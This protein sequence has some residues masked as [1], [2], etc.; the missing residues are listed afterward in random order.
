MKNEIIDLNH[1]W[2]EKKAEEYFLKMCGPIDWLA[3]KIVDIKNKGKNEWNVKV[4]VSSYGP[5]VMNNH[6]M[7]IEGKSFHCNVLSQIDREHVILI[8]AYMLTVGERGLSCK[9]LLEQYYIDTWGTAY[10]DASREILKLM[11]IEKAK[12][13]FIQNH[14]HSNYQNSNRRDIEE[15]KLLISDS[16]GPGYYGMDISSVDNFFHILD[17]DK[18][19]IKQ[20]ESGFMVP[21][22]SNVGFF[23]VTDKKIEIPYRDCKTCLGTTSGCDYCNSLKRSMNNDGKVKDESMKVTFLPQQIQIKASKEE[24][25]LD[26]ARRAG[27]FI[28]GTC[29]HTG[30]C[31]KCKVKITIGKTSDLDED[32][33]NR[34]TEEEMKKGYRLACKVHP[35][36]DVRVFV[37]ESE[38]K[39]KRKSELIYMPED[40]TIDEYKDQNGIAFDIGTTSVVALL[41][42][43]KQGK[44]IDVA[45]N[46]NPQRRYGADVISRITY[47]N[48]N[49]AHL[50]KMQTLVI[51]CCNQLIEELCSNNQIKIDTIKEFTMVGNTTM[52]H[53]FFGANINGLTKAPF[54]PSFIGEQEEMISSLLLKGNHNAPLYMLPGIAGHVGSDITAGILAM[55]L[56]DTSGVHIIIDIGTNGEIVLSN[57]GRIFVCSTA[58]G[59]AFEG[60]GIKCGMRASAGAIEGVK[61]K[62]GKVS[63]TVIEHKEPIGI[64]GSGLIDA[65]SEML[66]AGLI[67]ETGRILDIET[68]TKKN[69]SKELISRI[70]ENESNTAFVLAFSDKGSNEVVITQE[71]IRQIQLAKGAIY[72]GVLALLEIAKVKIEMIDS[73][74]LA[75]TFGNYIKKKSAVRIGLI[76]NIPL[77]KIIPVGNLAGTGASM[78]LLSKRERQRATLLV[79]EI[80]HIDLAKDEVFKKEYIHAMNFKVEKE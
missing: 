32:E 31:G 3:D 53:L 42:D 37:T 40:F 2:I 14:T 73:I 12:T 59:P 77:D 33:K 65:I 72:A 55:R 51:E 62:D 66:Q 67:D 25:I 58:A 30:R 11:L 7:I 1:K 80:Q 20:M 36:S 57:N 50:K 54:L 48:D 39:D 75:G 78:A 44:L 56:Q 27:V 5:E 69:I 21:A 68:A 46:M 9:D 61:I 74:F 29:N 22:K 49:P 13:D 52:S 17:G 43:M 8:Y 26:I 28:D 15:N 4:I 24:N 76:Q 18:I 47:C 34:L 63:L 45:A 79:K 60:A 41:W 71:D 38:K 64:C 23:L 10:V 70:R 35:Y 16:F 19:G 6:S